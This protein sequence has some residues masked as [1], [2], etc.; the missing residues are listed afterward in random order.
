VFPR[1]PH[2][3]YTRTIPLNMSA[4]AGAISAEYAER[5]I[6]RLD[7]AAQLAV[8]VD[9]VKQHP[10]TR[11][12]V[13]HRF[14]AE[15]DKPVDLQ[16]FGSQAWHALH[17]LDKLRPSQQY[18]QSGRV[19]EDLGKVITKATNLVNPKNAFRALVRIAGEMSHADS[20]PGEIFKCCVSHTMGDVSC[21]LV[22]TIERM[23]DTEGLKEDSDKLEGYHAALAD[24]HAIED[25]E[26]PLTLLRDG[27]GAGPSGVSDAEDGGEGATAEGRAKRQRVD[28]A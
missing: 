3:H 8:L 7:Q 24:D 26:E 12:I 6:K 28:G 13:K 15:M 2:A 19:S 4:A 25:L 23:A 16:Q 1:V 18:Q 5:L 11:A 10:Q 17:Q 9:I 22:S 27:V 20:I 21:A 14:D